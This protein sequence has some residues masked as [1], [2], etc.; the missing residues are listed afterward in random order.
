MG[1]LNFFVDTG[2]NR[3]SLSFDA[4]KL[5][6]ATANVNRGSRDL[7][8]GAGGSMRMA[9]EYLPK[10]MAIDGMRMEGLGLDL[11]SRAREHED[12][13]L[14]RDGTL[15]MDILQCYRV[16]LDIPARFMSLEL[17]PKEP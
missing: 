3:S 13:L 6:P 5:I 4:A 1:R 15:G 7:A 16:T 2:A 10:W 9:G 12:D 17:P 14:N 11:E 8:Q